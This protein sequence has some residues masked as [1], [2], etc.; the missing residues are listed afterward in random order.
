MF[1]TLLGAVVAALGYSCRKM[2][3]GEEEFMVLE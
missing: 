1:A 2:P 3:A